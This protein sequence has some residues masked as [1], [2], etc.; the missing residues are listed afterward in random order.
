MRDLLAATLHTIGYILLTSA[1]VWLAV[2]FAPELP[3]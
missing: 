1:A 2:R 3:R